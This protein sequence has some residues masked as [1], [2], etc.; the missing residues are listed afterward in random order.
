LDISFF[1]FNKVIDFHFSFS[2]HV[3]FWLFFFLFSGVWMCCTLFLF[4]SF[5]WSG[6]GRLLYAKW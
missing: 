6:Y 2:F 5:Y 4:N 3:C 1:Y